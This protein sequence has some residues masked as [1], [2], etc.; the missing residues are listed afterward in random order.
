MLYILEA[1][2]PYQE[3]ATNRFGSGAYPEDADYFRWAGADASVD[4]WVDDD[5]LTHN[6]TDL[7]N[8]TPQYAIV[9]FEGTGTAHVRYGLEAPTA[10][11]G[12]PYAA[13]S[14]LLVK[15]PDMLRLLKA[16]LPTGLSMHISPFRG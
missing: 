12:I 15:S 6:L 4:P 2:I 13:G 3:G 14:Q 11:N 1:W 16:Y 7:G 8:D 9:A 10:T 5:A